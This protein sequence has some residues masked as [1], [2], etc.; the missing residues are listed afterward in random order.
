MR[1]AHKNS[2]IQLCSELQRVGFD[3]QWPK[4][5]LLR[6][7]SGSETAKHWHAKASLCR[8]ISELNDIFF[9]EV[10]SERGV[11]DILRLKIEDEKA[12]IYEVETGYDKETKREKALQYTDGFSC[13][14]VGDVFVVDPLDAPDGVLDLTAWAEEVVV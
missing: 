6:P 9:T 8:R 3:V 5:N 7:H 4:R 14:V 2:A 12:Y 13:P 11:P 10:D 1:G